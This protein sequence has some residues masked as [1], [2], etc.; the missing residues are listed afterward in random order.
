MYQTTVTEYQLVVVTPVVT[1]WSLVKKSL[2]IFEK[3]AIIREHS[4][5]VDKV[6]VSS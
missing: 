3:P 6:V 4:A 2:V 5:K 1:F